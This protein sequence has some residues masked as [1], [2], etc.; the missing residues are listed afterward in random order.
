MAFDELAQRLFGA[1][2]A[3]SDA[4]LTDATTG[5]IH[6]VALTDSEGGA[7]TVE[8][9]A[10]V[11]A[12]EPLEVGGE[13]YF[14]DAGVGVEIP[15]S[16]SVRAG[17][18][19]LVSTYGAGTMRSPVVT[20]AVGS[21]DRMAQAVTEAHDLAASVES[22][23]QEAQEVA[24]A[25]G[26]HFWSDTDG[27]HVTEV[28]QTEWQTTPS[29]ANVLI[30]SAGQLFRSV[31]NNLLAILPS[32]IAIY[33][34]TGNTADHILAEFASD[35]VRIG[36]AI[37]EDGSAVATV[38][39]FDSDA[40]KGAMLTGYVDQSG[41]ATQQT[42]DTRTQLRTRTHD[43]DMPT[44]YGAAGESGLEVGQWLHAE[45]GSYSTVESTATLTATAD[46][47]TDPTQTAHASA[48]LGVK[49]V[50]VDDSAEEAY[51]TVN[52]NDVPMPQAI[53]VLSSPVTLFTGTYAQTHNTAVTLSETASNFSRMLIEWETGDGNQGS[54]ML[55]NPN[56][57]RFEAVALN[58]NTGTNPVTYIKWKVFRVNGT[59]ISNYS[60]DGTN[61]NM[62]R[63][64]VTLRNNGSVTT[65]RNEYIGIIRV[66][67]WR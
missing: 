33:D 5:T 36:G 40:D 43:A 4:I 46:S 2:R 48:S 42:Q 63:G 14:A 61:A 49:A 55:S 28:T 56:G 16:E 53:A 39:F 58:C 24:Q 35:E 27:I 23:A 11:T 32:G 22:I 9:T 59:T 50:T 3:E 45:T 7:V 60:T 20:A 65:T 1:R 8:I 34:G 6:G 12:P 41:D 18:E 66:L 10:D 37:P 30:N 44:T 17:D 57:K 31:L 29:G 51:I 54:T 38:R 15:T 21:G 52:G 64:E 25:T 19:V 67:G 62:Q 47:G 26:Q 13:T